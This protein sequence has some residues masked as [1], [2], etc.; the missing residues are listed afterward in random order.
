[1]QNTLRHSAFLTAPPSAVSRIAAHRFSRRVFGVNP[2]EVS[3]FV[4]AVDAT[5][6][7][8]VDVFEHERTALE[9]QLRDAAAE[10]ETL[11]AGLNAAE[12]SAAAYQEQEAVIARTL[13]TAQKTADELVR[14]AQA[15]ADEL[16]GKAE[17]IATD[18]VQAGCRTATEILQKAQ[19]D[20][21]DIVEAARE[22]G[23][24]LLTQL[25]AAA[26][27]LVI[28]AHQTFRQAQRSVEHDVASLLER[29]LE[30]RHADLRNGTTVEPLRR[31]KAPGSETEPETADTTPQ[32]AVL[33]VGAA[34][35]GAGAEAAVP[36]ERV[37]DPASHSAREGP[38][39]VSPLSAVIAW[40]I[41][42]GAISV[43]SLL[44]RLAAV[45]RA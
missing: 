35:P 6:E 19:Q 39:Q 31:L 33:E 22:K 13:L 29:C 12:Q 38:L 15:D 30:D 23:A 32:S 45:L 1:M 18:V 41:M 14:T 42:G 11:R 25:Q 4:A 24:A 3:Q 21:D 27:R 43:F 28:D 8:L 37:T 36:A 26:D 2:R 9:A 44:R 7:D 10:A 34:A 20:A 16:V 5:V 40:V 17:M